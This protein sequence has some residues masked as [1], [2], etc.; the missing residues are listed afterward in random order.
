VPSRFGLPKDTLGLGTEHERMAETCF[1][2][3]FRLDA[4]ARD[5]VDTIVRPQELGYRHRDILRAPPTVERPQNTADQ[6]RGA[7]Q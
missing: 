5:V 1:F 6:L 4:V 3:L 2:H 7:T